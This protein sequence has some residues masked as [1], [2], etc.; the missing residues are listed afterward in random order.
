[1]SSPSVVHNDEVTDSAKASSKAVKARNV[2]EEAVPDLVRLVHG[3]INNK[4][5]LAREFIAFWGKKHSG[6]GDDDVVEE[7]ATPSTKSCFISKRKMIDKITEIADYKKNP[8]GVGRC[9]IVKEELL[10]KHPV[11]QGQEWSYILEQPNN[12]TSS[13][14]S[15]D[16]SANSRPESPA[17]KVKIRYL[18]FFL[19]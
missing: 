15:E 5:F 6:A 9:W 19:I 1:M 13:N 7:G 14:N 16:I 17:G 18:Y 12:K 8:E 10:A 11:T 2:P 3:N 4:V